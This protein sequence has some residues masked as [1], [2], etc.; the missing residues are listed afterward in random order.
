MKKY[1][2]GGLSDFW[3]QPASSFSCL[4][5]APFFVTGIAYVQDLRP[6]HSPAGKNCP[7]P[8]SVFWAV[9]NYGYPQAK[10]YEPSWGGCYQQ[11]TKYITVNL[12]YSRYLK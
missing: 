9:W 4:I 7:S 11:K 2:F 8:I 5:S 1:S 3:D 10:K 6:D 12:V